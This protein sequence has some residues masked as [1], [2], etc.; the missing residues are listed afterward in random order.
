MSLNSCNHPD[1]PES[2]KRRLVAERDRQNNGIAHID[3]NTIINV[4][5]ILEPE[6]APIANTIMSITLI[7]A[8][9]SCKN[10]YSDLLPRP[11]K[12]NIFLRQI[13]TASINCNCL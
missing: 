5:T 9:A 10:Q 4:V 6:E 12:S 11:E 13:S 8:N 3:N 2:C 7:K 1:F